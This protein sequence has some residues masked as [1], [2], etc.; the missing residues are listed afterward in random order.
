M[1]GSDAT[2]KKDRPIIGRERAKLDEF[3]F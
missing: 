1:S 2:E 3:A